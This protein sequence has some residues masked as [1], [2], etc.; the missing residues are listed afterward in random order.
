MNVW[1]CR[2]DRAH[3]GKGYHMKDKEPLTEKGLAK[4]GL[5]QKALHTREKML[6]A[7]IEQV[8][9][10][11]Y[12]NIT[13]DDIAR[14]CGMSTGCAYRYFRNKKDMLIAAIEYCFE[15]IQEFSGTEDSRLTEC[16]NLEEMLGYALDRFYILHKKYYAIHE[17][18][19][20]LRHIDDDIRKTYDRIME[21]AIDALI[22]KCRA[23]LGDIPDIRERLYVALGILDNYAHMQMEETGHANV[24]MDKLK[25]LCIASVVM[26]M[27]VESR[28]V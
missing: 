1:I 2:F 4:S 28:S 3:I 8:A 10:H 19:E 14:A 27:N 5:T 13:V 15:N 12:H 9:Q 21:N 23:V 25:E 20:S 24:D 26:V 17:E 16:G 7:T 6:K 18:L 11:G 22:P